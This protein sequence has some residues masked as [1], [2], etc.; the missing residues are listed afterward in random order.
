METVWNS[1]TLSLIGEDGVSAL[2]RARVLV[3]GV[4]GVGGY[5]V[6]MLARAGVGHLTLV[7]A[8]TV[9]ETNLNRQLIAL[10]STLNRPKVQLFKERIHDI[11]PDCEVDALS[12]FLTPEGVSPLL[13][14]GFDFVADCIDTVA[15]K[16]ALLAE[17]HFRRVKV[18]S[19]MGAGGRLDP[20]QVQYADLWDTRQD[21][22]A[23]AVRE[24]LK[25]KH[26]HPALPVVYSPEA[27]R[28]SALLEELGLNNKRSSY[29]TLATIP[30]LFGIYMASYII[31][32]LTHS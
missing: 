25:R 13:D 30:S 22:L 32:K 14:L 21:G 6:E 10:R 20:A 2:A 17:C 12:C 23:R 19:S 26:L 8:D 9:S 11:S 5:V 16:V 1:R 15:P 3:V 28:R 7:D 27:P 31:R 24:G 4:G 29:G 18:I